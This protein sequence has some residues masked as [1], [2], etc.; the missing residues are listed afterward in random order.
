MLFEY[1]RLGFKSLFRKKI[2]TFLTICSIAI[3]V[4]SVILISTIS[5]VGKTTINEELSSL[6]LD[7]ITLGSEKQ[8]PDAHLG[9]EE[10]TLIRQN[11]QVTAASPIMVRYTEAKLRGMVANTVVWGIDQG[12]EQAIS[13]ETIYGRSFRSNDISNARRV[14]IVD[15]N[16][17]Q[18]FYKRDNIVGKTLRLRMEDRYE[19][20][21]VIGV[22]KS[23][24]NLLQGLMEG[25]IP[26]FIYLPYTAMMETSGKERFDQV[27]IKVEPDADT[28]AVGEEL[29]SVLSRANQSYGGYKTENILQQKESLNGILDTVTLI[30]SL[31]AAIS[32]V[33]AGL[34]VMTVMTV[35]VSERTKEIGIKK[36]IGAAKHTILLEFLTETFIM[37]FF[38]SILGAALGILFS[39]SGCLIAGVPFLLDYP[40]LG[41]CLIFTTASGLI[42]GVYPACAA[43]RMNPVDALRQE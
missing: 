33:V 6:G 26:S 1:I 10:L 28:D 24:G 8:N 29:I 21:E 15:Q 14:C 27:I 34:G 16:V 13:L 9:A 41:L 2:R 18:A 17:A 19:Y 31:I 35:S 38:G 22:V 43:A 4:S 23:G 32:L 5:Q 37:M 12:A 20:F 25:Y 11:E 40:M 36:S 3:G 7:G 39:F 42:F 30:L